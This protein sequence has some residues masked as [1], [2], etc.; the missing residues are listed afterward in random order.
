MNYSVDINRK[1]DN[2]RTRS[3]LL[4]NTELYFQQ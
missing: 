2:N 4:M 1:K 3:E